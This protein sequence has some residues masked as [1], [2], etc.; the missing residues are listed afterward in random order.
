MWLSS[1][2]GAARAQASQHWVGRAFALHAPMCACALLS[3]CIC[4]QRD[5]RSGP[6]PALERR[7]R[8]L[9]I[10]ASRARHAGC[11]RWV[12][13]PACSKS[14]CAAMRQQRA[15]G[16]AS[17]WGNASQPPSRVAT[18]VGGRCRAASPPPIRRRRGLQ[19][20]G[21]ERLPCPSVYDRG[22]AT[23]LLPSSCNYRPSACRL[24]AWQVCCVHIPS[25]QGWHLNACCS[26]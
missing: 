22:C 11:G 23:C 12:R 6:G 20:V 5:I 15:D 16:R 17:R 13:R 10:V 26:S 21:E 14:A 1:G 24:L 8:A 18:P 9:H 19:L 2:R 25:A 3:L 7:G 4:L